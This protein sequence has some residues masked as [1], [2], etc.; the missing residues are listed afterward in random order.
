MTHVAFLGDGEKNFALPY[1]QLIELE[2]KTG[3]GIGALFHRVRSLTFG[4]ADIAE[5]IRLGL[6]GGGTDPETAF[7]LID[8]YVKR[9]PL[10]ETLPVALGIL[11]AVWFGSPA[12]AQADQD[13]EATHG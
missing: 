13:Q 1:D 3:A 7:L 4:I 11:E 2:A 10:A 12:D 8:Q 5:T 9:R 6:I